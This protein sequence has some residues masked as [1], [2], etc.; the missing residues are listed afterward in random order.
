MIQITR[1]EREA[2]E[3]VGLLKYRRL[4][5]HPQDQNFVVTNKEHVGRNKR[6]YVAE[7]PDI[8]LFLG[9]YDGMNLQNVSERQVNNLLKE[10]MIAENQVQHWMEYKPNAVVFEDQ[11]GHYHMKKVAKLMLFLGIWKPRKP[12]QGQNK[13]Q[14][15][16]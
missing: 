3:S 2:L 1:Q 7:E 11:F 13:D 8:M 4:G 5:F 12:T 10:K 9:H 15:Q 16:Q 6:I 14:N